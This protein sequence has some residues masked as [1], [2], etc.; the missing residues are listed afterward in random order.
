VQRRHDEN[1]NIT[2]I[3]FGEPLPTVPIAYCNN[4][5]GGKIILESDNTFD[6][7]SLQRIATTCKIINNAVVRLIGAVHRRDTEQVEETSEQVRLGMFEVLAELQRLGVP[8][9]Q[10]DEHISETLD[11]LS[12]ELLGTAANREL[13]R[14][15]E[16][17]YRVA[18]TVDEERGRRY[19][20]VAHTLLLLL[21]RV[22]R[23]IETG[24][25]GNRDQ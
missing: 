23:E 3:Y 21:S 4:Y 18:D 16:Q 15:L 2:R 6:K 5:V 14:L 8:G 20:T 22:E 1:G 24:S 12:P 13:Y 25:E 9:T 19:D 11:Y 10:I 17:A 7:S